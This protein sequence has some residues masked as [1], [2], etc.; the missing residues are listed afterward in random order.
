MAKE[1]TLDRLAELV[2]EGFDKVDQKFEK[3]DGKI[4]GMKSDL[5]K[6]SKKVDKIEIE[7][8]GI[9]TDIKE[10]ASLSDLTALERRVTFLEAQLQRA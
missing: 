8:K 4:E 6:V 9:R 2:V 10:K 1:I 3:I 5:A 7:V